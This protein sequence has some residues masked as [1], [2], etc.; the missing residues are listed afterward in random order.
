MPP[1]QYLHLSQDL[2]VKGEDATRKSSELYGEKPPQS[3]LIQVSVPK[4]R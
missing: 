4:P 1:G 2:E 3:K